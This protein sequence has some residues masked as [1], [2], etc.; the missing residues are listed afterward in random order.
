MPAL[1]NPDDTVAGSVRSG[2]KH[3]ADTDDSLLN[4]LLNAYERSERSDS[5]QAHSEAIERGTP[6][7]ATQG[8]Q[9]ENECPMTSDERVKMVQ[10]MALHRQGKSKRESIETVWGVKKGGSPVWKRASTLFDLAMQ[11]ALIL[12]DDDD[13]A[14]PLAFK[15]LL[16]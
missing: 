4:A 6:E 9:G 3:V 10:T 12:S 14:P 8:V 2:Q 13:D 16:G 11:G 15:A 1:P 7:R 5:V